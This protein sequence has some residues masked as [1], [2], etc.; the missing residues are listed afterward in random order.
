LARETA[1]AEVLQVA[2]RLPNRLFGH[3]AIAVRRS[4]RF[5]HFGSRETRFLIA[6]DRGNR[7]SF[8][9]EPVNGIPA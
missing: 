3:R 1:I 4:E 8:V 7:D 9:P 6:C 5:D 2:R